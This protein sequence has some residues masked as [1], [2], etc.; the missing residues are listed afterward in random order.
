ML[1]DYNSQIINQDEMEKENEELKKY[2]EEE[3]EQNKEISD[4]N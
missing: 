4:E 2:L 1:E 3:I